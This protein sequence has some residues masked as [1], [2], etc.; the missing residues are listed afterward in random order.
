M[1]K[2]RMSV[3]IRDKDY[4][5]ERDHKLALMRLQEK[6]QTTVV[7]EDEQQGNPNQR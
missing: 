5:V 2:R 6:F 7:S 4:W 3:T 1:Y